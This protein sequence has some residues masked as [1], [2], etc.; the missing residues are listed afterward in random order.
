MEML[1]AV[2]KAKAVT[3]MATTVAA[4]VG[5]QQLPSNKVFLLYF[6][7]QVQGGESGPFLPLV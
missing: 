3:T 5:W 2:R 6:Q 1:K 4:E 7:W